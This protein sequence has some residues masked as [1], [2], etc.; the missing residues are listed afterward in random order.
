MNSD[1]TC[2]FEHSKISLQQK[3]I[4]FRVHESRK[5]LSV[6][7]R[8]YKNIDDALAATKIKFKIENNKNENLKHL[9]H[10]QQYLMGRFYIYWVNTLFQRK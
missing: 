9:Q 5:A 6:I 4:Y 8:Q 3:N 1:R 10:R 2:K 7:K